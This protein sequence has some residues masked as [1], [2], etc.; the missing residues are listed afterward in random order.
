VLLITY[1]SLIV[2]ELVPKRLALDSPE[3]IAAAVAGPMSLLSR[4][5]A[6]MV[7]ILSFST[8]ALLK[9]F[10]LRDSDEPA[11]TVDDVRGLIRMGTRTGVFEP[12]EQQIVERVFRF[13]DRR[14]SAIMTPRGNV[15][16]LNVNDQH[17]KPSGEEGLQS[18][19]QQIRTQ[20]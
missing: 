16:W 14:V 19:I 15:A 12:G 4:I 11:V 17:S 3:Q 9:V 8:D 2:G 6:P 13:A 10:R 5:G 7:A 18:R 20:R 1:L